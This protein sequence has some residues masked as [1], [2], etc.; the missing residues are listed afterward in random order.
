MK[1]ANAENK[2]ILDKDSFEFGLF[3]GFICGNITMTLILEILTR[4]VH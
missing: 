3:V 1:Q 2:K 4:L